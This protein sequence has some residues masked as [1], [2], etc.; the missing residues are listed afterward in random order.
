MLP[1]VDIIIKHRL[2]VGVVTLVAGSLVVDSV[3]EESV[4]AKADQEW[5]ADLDGGTGT[6]E[7]E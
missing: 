1:A 3:G 5:F 6:S 4:E 7:L 2:E